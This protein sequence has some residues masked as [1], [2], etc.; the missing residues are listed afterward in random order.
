MH[1]KARPPQTL[2][3]E[4]PEV[5]DQHTAKCIRNGFGSKATLTP[6]KWCLLRR[7]HV[8]KYSNKQRQINEFCG[9]IL[10]RSRSEKRLRREV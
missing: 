9:M 3:L 10:W 8:T 5:T 4:G 7:T 6:C 1:L 2:G